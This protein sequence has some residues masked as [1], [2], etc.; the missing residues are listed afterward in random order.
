[1]RDYYSENSDKIMQY[2]MY[3]CGRLDEE[4]IKESNDIYGKVDDILF[5]ILGA[6]TD[7]EVKKL[8][9]EYISVLN[10]TIRFHKKS[11]NS[12]EKAAKSL[13]D[14]GADESD[15]ETAI[16]A[17]HELSDQA[18]AMCELELAA[19]KESLRMLNN[20]NYTEEAVGKD[21]NKKVL[22]KVKT[23]L[24]TS[25]NKSTKVMKMFRTKV[26][27]LIAA[28]KSSVRGK[29]KEMANKKKEGN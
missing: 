21:V 8:L 7:E 25:H 1:M 14:A 12:I 24:R 9:P 15:V 10:E 11:I 5:D 19:A 26:V 3:I 2:T 20:G 27:R 13:T 17:A 4:I 16:K 6:E 18:I 22:D 28:I 29:I 23:L